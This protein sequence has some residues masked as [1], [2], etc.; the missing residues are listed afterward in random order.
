MSATVFLAT[1]QHRTR[2]MHI[3]R[4]AGWPC[5]DPLEIDLLAAALVQLR[6]DAHGRDTL[7]LTEAGIQA[8]ADVRR[9]NQRAAS[10]HDRLA[11]RL[12]VQLQG[13][14]R[15][16]W[17]ELSLRALIETAPP[18]LPDTV[19]QEA[20]NASASAAGLMA[21]HEPGPT[22]LWP[23]L[24]SADDALTGL[25]SRSPL[26]SH[27]GGDHHWRMA[28]PDIFSIRNTTVE[29]YLRPM[30]HEIKVSRADL[31]SD[32]RHEAKRQAYQW[33]SCEC[34]YV[35]PASIAEP[36]EVPEAFG[37]WLLHGDLDTGRLEL[38]RPARH[39]P[40]TLPF[41]VWMAL[42]K[43]TPLGPAEEAAQSPLAPLD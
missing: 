3:W 16:V 4:S 34:Y 43:A 40:R 14:G 21:A 29:A 7:H 10:R 38:A 8:L 15:I 33:L 11:E 27:L 18:P 36:A 6:T 37:V 23:P 12:S 39:T 31:L 25:P 42:A 2:L 30:V 19:A 5:R 13:D 22:S 24:Q 41:A 20:M 9:S 17:R 35:F 1:R 28:R 32:L 26:S